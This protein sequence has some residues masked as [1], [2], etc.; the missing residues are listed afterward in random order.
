[1]EVFWAFSLPRIWIWVGNSRLNLEY[2]EGVVFACS[3]SVIMRVFFPRHGDWGRF[4]LLGMF[5]SYTAFGKKWTMID[6]PFRWLLDSLCGNVYRCNKQTGLKLKL[7]N[8]YSSC[9]V[10]MEKPTLYNNTGEL[11]AN[12]NLFDCFNGFIF[13]S[14]R[15]VFNKLHSKF[16]FYE[17]T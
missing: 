12:Q 2:E 7:V 10:V 8:F 16:F 3:L 11:Q 1:M 5:V 4:L 9:R 6:L 17:K 13:S 15:N 14:D